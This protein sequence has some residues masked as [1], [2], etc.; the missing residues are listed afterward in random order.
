MGRKRVPGL[1]WLDPQ[2]RNQREWA[3]NYLWAKDRLPDNKRPTDFIKD[4][5]I[6]KT[7][8]A[9]EL[10]ANGREVLKLMKEAW[11]QKRNKDTNIDTET[12]TFN[13]KAST[14]A[15]LRELAEHQ[16]KDMTSLLEA[17]IG[18]AY[19]SH[20]SKIKKEKAP[21]SKPEKPASNTFARGQ[22]PSTGTGKIDTSQ[23][24]A[25]PEESIQPNPRTSLAPSESVSPVASNSIDH[26]TAEP[27]ESVP[28][29]DFVMIGLTPETPTPEEMNH[30]YHQAKILAKEIFAGTIFQGAPTTTEEPT[31]PDSSHEI[32][33]PDQDP[34]L[35]TTEEIAHFRHQISIDTKNKLARKNAHTEAS[36]FRTAPAGTPEKDPRD[37]SPEPDPEL[38]EA[39][40]T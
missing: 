9:M 39:E 21:Q 19:K 3:L 2:D 28:P 31:L 13:L 11:R 1:E 38:N 14:K 12:C 34:D 40:S 26:T 4:A 8:A 24:S 10:T 20:Q 22:Q 25:Y 7:G 30:A 16:K 37:P 36:K 17:L 35:P 5:D 32:V 18:K 23:S 29:P 33:M 6:Q 15:S 27:N